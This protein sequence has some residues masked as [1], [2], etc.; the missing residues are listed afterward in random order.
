MKRLIAILGLSLALVSVGSAQNKCSALDANLGFTNNALRDA[1]AN[2]FHVISDDLQKLLFSTD[3]WKADMAAFLK[4]SPSD[5]PSN[6]MDRIS[7]RYNELKAVADND[8][9]TRT[10]KDRPFQR[11]VEQNLVKSKYTAKYPGV[12]ILKIGSNY[13]D[14]NVFKNSLGIPTN[15]YVRGEVLLQ[16]PGRPYCQAQEWVVKQQYK[17]GSYGASVAENVGGSGYFVM[18]P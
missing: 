16:I 3:A 2:S 15:R 8:G 4:C 14:W 11:A 5:F 1:L 6:W 18:C 17:G 10:W 13:K 12:K 7:E 9:K